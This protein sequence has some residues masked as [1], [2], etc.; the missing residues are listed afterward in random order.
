M[1]VQLLKPAG[2]HLMTSR[3]DTAL[4]GKGW[5]PWYGYF[6]WGVL[7]TVLAVVLFADSTWPVLAWICAISAPVG[8]Y[9]TW[10][11]WTRGKRNGDDA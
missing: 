4:N 8:F 9:Y 6:A 7:Y 3:T 2:L 5:M 10:R 11:A 1:S